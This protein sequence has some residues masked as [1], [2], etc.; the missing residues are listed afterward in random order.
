MTTSVICFLALPGGKQD[1]RD[2]PAQE[3]T[4]ETGAGDLLASASDCGHVGV[5]AA[6]I[7][8]PVGMAFYNIAG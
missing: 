2:R 3:Q 6:M 5:N 8:V 4:L 1:Q 7:P